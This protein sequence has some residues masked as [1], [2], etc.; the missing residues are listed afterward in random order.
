MRNPRAEPH[1]PSVSQGRGWSSDGCSA[2]VSCVPTR[3]SGSHLASVHWLLALT[4]VLAAQVARAARRWATSQLARRA[5]HVRR[6][7]IV[8]RPTRRG[9]EGFSGSW[10]HLR[11]IFIDA[12]PWL[13]QG[14]GRPVSRAHMSEWSR[15]V[16]GVERMDRG[17]L[18]CRVRRKNQDLTSHLTKKRSRPFLSEFHKQ[19]ELRAP[20]RPRSFANSFGRVRPQ[21]KST[22]RHRAGARARSLTC[23]CR[24][25]SGA[26]RRLT[27][28]DSLE[29]L[30]SPL[31]P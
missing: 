25:H 18:S 20:R 8:K 29:L 21:R 12:A 19:L 13:E 26:L 11:R 22:A 6:R 31:L 16:E 1:E 9:L 28:A 30:S 5:Q 4:K 23:L 14:C 15:S 10:L 27:T 24:Y 7:G 17:T 2:L 3:K